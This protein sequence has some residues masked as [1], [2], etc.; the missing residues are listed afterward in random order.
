M[1]NFSKARDFN[2]SFDR[3]RRSVAEKQQ[4]VEQAQ[5]D[6]QNLFDTCPDINSERDAFEVSKSPFMNGGMFCLSD[7][8]IQ[9]LD[10]ANEAVVIDVEPAP[11][12]ARFVYDDYCDYDDYIR[13]LGSRLE[14]FNGEVLIDRIPLVSRSNVSISELPQRTLFRRMAQIKSM[15][16]DLRRDTKHNLDVASNF[17][18][19]VDRIMANPKQYPKSYAALKAHFDSLETAD[20]EQ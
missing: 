13:G 2:E 20:E 19:F 5:I 3:K 11:L 9:A 7:E 4:E 16:H 18:I 8:T 12:D 1:T 6:K 17:K 14:L 10:S 15:K